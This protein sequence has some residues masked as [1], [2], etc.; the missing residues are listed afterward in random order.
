MNLKRGALYLMTGWFAI[1]VTGYGLNLVLARWFP[2]GSFGDYGTVMTLLLWIEIF[3]IT[4]LPFAV[5]KFVSAH[6]TEGRSIF[7][8]ALRIQAAV[9]LGL[10]AL[11]VLSAPLFAGLFRDARLT[12]YFRLAFLNLP[13]Y[14]FFHLVVSYHN[15]RRSFAKQGFCY[16]FYGLAKLGSVLLLCRFHPSLESAF[17]GNILGSALSLAFA[18]ALVNDRGARPSRFGREL[19]RFAL[20]ALLYSLMTQLLMSVDL[21]SVRT[22]FGDKASGQYYVAATLSRIP[23]Y[24]LAGLSAVLMPV[25]SE[26]LSSGAVDRAGRTM[27]NAVRYAAILL[28]PLCLLMTVY[29]KEILTLLFPDRFLPAG[30]V[31]G[32]LAC[33]MTAMALLNM[34]LTLI[35]ADGRPSQSSRIAA[36]SVAA[37]LGLIAL[38][39]PRY[40]APGAAWASLAAIGLA[41]VWGA[42]DILRKYAAFPGLPSIGR[43]GLATAGLL[44][45]LLLI[46]VRGREFIAAGAAGIA[47]FGGVLLL[48]GELRRDDLKVFSPSP[49][50]VPPPESA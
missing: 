30:P 27:R 11:L 34:L 45:C 17:A 32:V 2:L 26:A 49:G 44:A 33:A 31:L 39:A 10:T 29:R 8:A 1:L 42:A 24:A 6:E 16:V 40:G 35:S 22:L 19:I 20:P 21:W 3:V 43:I 9:T 41:C 18:W 23:Y 50:P 4:G 5:Q 14:G 38:L 13:F 36:A 7:W 12:P 46:P 37:D 28:V 15:G 25:I 47:V 48:T